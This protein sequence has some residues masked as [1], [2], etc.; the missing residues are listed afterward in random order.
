MPLHYADS[1]INLSALATVPEKYLIFY[2]SEVNGQMWCPVCLAIKNIYRRKHVELKLIDDLWFKDCRRVDSLVKSA[3]SEE[4]GP[5]GL[6]VFVGDRTQ[7]VTLYFEI[8]Y[9]Y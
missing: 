6:I 2:S 5:D 8:Y 9:L 7:S 4:T 3:F 1:S